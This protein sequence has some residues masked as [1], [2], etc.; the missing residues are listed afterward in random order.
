M[1]LEA[2]SRGLAGAPEAVARLRAVAWVMPLAA[3]ACLLVALVLWAA[4]DFAPPPA[5]FVRGPAIPAAQLAVAAAYA[6]IGLFLARNLPRHAHGWM[7]QVVGVVS[8]LVVLESTY[9]AF[10]WE[11]TR[12]FTGTET[13]AWLVS[14]FSFPIVFALGPT[15]IVLFPDGRL[16]GRRWWLVVAASLAGAALLAVALAFQPGPISYF[17]ALVN[18]FAAQGAASRLVALA[19]PLSLV[20][21]V[22]AL[23]AAV[24]ATVVRY[25]GADERER[26]QLKWICFGLVLVA[27]TGGFYVAGFTL[28]GYYSDVGELSAFVMTV[29]TVVPPIAAAIA[30]RRHRLYD[31]DLI[32]NRT[33]VYLPLTAVLGGLYSASVV[34][35]Q[36]VFVA[37]TGNTS[38]AAIVLSTLIL[39]GAFTPL[40]DELKALADRRFRPRRDPGSPP[41]VHDAGE[42]LTRREV[43]MIAARVARDV[44]AAE[45]ARARTTPASAPG[46]GPDRPS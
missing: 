34:F 42:A 46:S 30:I 2:A 13:S 9:L 23:A 26:L 19:L 14:S 41:Q 29:S 43:E 6:A 37:L 5:R 20:L 35:F 10:T 8:A 17:P 1:G 11:R 40:R 25:R 45:L 15:T 44:V 18:P 7:F 38:D 32:I 22:S 27:V 39:A 21:I 4:V 16:P 24:A 12:S 33:L 36:R 3:W 31:I 28:F